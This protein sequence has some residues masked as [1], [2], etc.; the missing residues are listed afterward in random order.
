MTDFHAP[1]TP[2]RRRTLI[3]GG[4]IAILALVGVA[5]LAWALLHGDKGAGDAGGPGGPGGPGGFGGGGRRGPAS[6]VAVA[7]ATT[8]DLPIIIDALGTVK[9]AATVTVRPQVSGTIT[10]VMFREGQAVQRG[11][12]LVQIDPRPY[13]MALLQA[14]GNQTRD[15]AQLAAARLTLTRYQTLLTQDSI[16][17]QEVDTQAATVK[18]LEGTVMADRAA[19][20]TARLNLGFARITA[21]VSGRVG[22]RV[23][24]VGNYIGAGDTNGVAVITTV[25]P[26]DVEFTVP[27]D[28]VPRIAARQGRASLPVTALDRTRAQTLDRGTFSTLD[29]LVDTGTGTVKAKARFPNVG[30]TLFPSQFVNVRMELDT[31]KG[32]IVVPATAVRQSSDGSFVWL[33]NSDQTVKKTPV[34]T[35]QATGVQV[36]V[37]QGLKAGDKVITEGGDRLRDGG[38]VQLPGARP[39]GQGKGKGKGDGKGHRQR[40]QRPE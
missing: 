33:L 14:Q 10:E 19:V 18:Q 7:T 25:S 5:W 31:I 12:P 11:Q 9:P 29:N 24:D 1:R 40:P 21:P 8:T 4:L 34:K 15:E 35:G 39:A 16:A 6:T 38:K 22:L 30:N 3:L 2:P 13:Q 28:D 17:R 20:G 32:A 23:V 36:Q 26:I 27:Q 37:T